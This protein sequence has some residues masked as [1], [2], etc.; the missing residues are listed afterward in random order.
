MPDSVQ[1]GMSRSRMVLYRRPSKAFPPVSPPMAF[2]FHPHRNIDRVQYFLFHQYPE[3]TLGLCDD[4]RGLR[5]CDRKAHENCL[6]MRIAQ[7][8]EIFT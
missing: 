6:R 1:I 2:G 8:V 3:P 4:F 5:D 7:R